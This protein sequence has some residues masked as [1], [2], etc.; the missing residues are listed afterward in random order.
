[1]LVYTDFRTLQTP[2]EGTTVTIGNFDGLHFGHTV[3]LSRARADASSNARTFSVLSFS[4]HPAQ[5]LAPRFAPP[6]IYRAQDKQRLLERGGVELLLNQTFDRAFAA[7]TPDQFVRQV[8]VSALGAR[9]V[10]V[11]YDFSFGAKR[12]GNFNMLR[13]LGAELGFTVER[14]EA[15]QKADIVASSTRVRELIREGDMTAT[16]GL[17]GRPYH[18]VGRVETGAQRGGSLGFPTAN[19]APQEAL[20]PKPG[21]YSG[22]LDWGQSPQPC[23]TNIGQNPT[24]GEGRQRT[25]EA[26]VIDAADLKLYGKVAHLFF[27]RRLRDERKFADISSL[28]EQIGR[29]RDRARAELSAQAAPASFF[30]RPEQPGAV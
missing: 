16:S 25:V 22:W 5:L 6:L 12:A 2:A 26:H 19:L 8:L 29:D 3:L 10:V 1:M 14:V 9:H 18:I 30:D 11:G 28:R 21:V 13:A 24:F 23:V 27:E 17:L 15:Q 4:P 7:L 20:L